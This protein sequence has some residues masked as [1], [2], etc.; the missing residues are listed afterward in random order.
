[1]ISDKTSEAIEELQ[2][3]ACIHGGNAVVLSNTSDAGFTGAFGGYSQQVAKA[4]GVAIF[5]EK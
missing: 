3:C 1:M 5:I 2:R 4:K